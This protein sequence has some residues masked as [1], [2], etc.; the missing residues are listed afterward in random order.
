MMGMTKNIVA[1]H[2]LQ[3]L[4]NDEYLMRV[5]AVSEN[6]YRA[7]FER[8]KCIQDFGFTVMSR[9]SS[10]DL[11][12]LL[13][14]LGVTGI[15]DACA[16]SGWVAGMLAAHTSLDVTASDLMQ[17]GKWPFQ[18]GRF[19]PTEQE[20]AVMIAPRVA[21]VG[22]AL[23]LPWVDYE[24]TWGTEAVQAFRR[25][26]GRTVVLVHEGEWGC[27]AHPSLFEELNVYWSEGTEVPLKSWDSIHDRLEVFTLKH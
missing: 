3:L 5:L 19:H 10:I 27:I 18:F 11:E 1:E 12:K 14:S 24:A 9:S 13:H 15:H 21:A 16:G 17:E 20:D 22:K 26:G 7:A 2:D 8:P 25:A 4:K 6:F 23:L